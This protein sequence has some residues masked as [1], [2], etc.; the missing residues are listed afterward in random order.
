MERKTVRL[1]YS[2][3]HTHSLDELD[4]KQHEQRFFSEI[5]EHLATASSILI[6]GPGVTKHHFQNYLM[7]HFP[8]LSRRV[9]GC[10]TSDHPTDSQIAAMAK[11]AL[12]R[13]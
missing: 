3:H 8:S 10:E 4:Q 7:E 9:I 2:N 1:C 5:I 11:R 6:L 13:I 12:A